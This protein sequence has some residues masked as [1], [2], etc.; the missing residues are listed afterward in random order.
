MKSRIKSEKRMGAKGIE[1]QLRVRSM[2]LCEET[3]CKIV[4]WNRTVGRFRTKKGVRQGCSL[5]AIIIKYII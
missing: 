4:K 1:R 3:I 2:E 5:R